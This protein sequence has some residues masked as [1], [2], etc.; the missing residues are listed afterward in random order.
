MKAYIDGSSNGLY[1]YLL[2]EKQKTVKDYPMTNNQ[3]EWLA[4]LTLLMDLDPN[5][6]INIYSDSQ[7]VVNQFSGE[8]E[9]KNETLK[10]LKEV[11]FLIVKTKRLKITMHWV[12]RERNPYGKILEKIIA[13]ERK[14]RKK[15]REKVKRGW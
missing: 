9:T 14:K 7:I 10:H 13:K 1:G 6:K 3:A 2:N 11:C 12:P 15:F 5:T 8:W 4:L